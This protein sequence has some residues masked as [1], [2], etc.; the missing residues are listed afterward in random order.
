MEVLVVYQFCTFGGVERMLL[1]RAIAFKNAEIDVKLSIGY[2]HDSGA[3]QDFQGFVAAQDLSS[4]VDP[5]I[6]ESPADSRLRREYGLILVIDTPDAL[7]YLS[8]RRNLYVECHT[9]YRQN[10]KYLDR[11]PKSVR[12]V[13]VP[14]DSF[15]HLIQGEFPRLPPL[16]T[17][18]NPI[19]GDFFDCPAPGA[20]IF[21]KRP[22]AYLGR[23][24][25]LK[26]A[27]EAFQVFRQLA[28]VAEVMFFIVGQGA[29]EPDTLKTLS[30][31]G[32]LGKAF[33]RNNLPFES[34]PSLVGMVKASRGAYF[35]PSKGESFGLSVAEFMAGGVPV[36]VSDIPAHRE[37]VD[38]DE[39]FLYKLGDIDAAARGVSSLL[40]HWDAMSKLASRYAEKFRQDRFV[41][42][43][44]SL[45]DAAS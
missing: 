17:L 35:S 8:G 28:Q 1:N 30:A 32:I 31:A 37:L 9:P 19:P 36:V 45:F 4:G 15:G 23:L 21:A 3:L 41:Q 11:I 5:F 13:I 12:G 39:R 22:I 40:E 2:L 33:I 7:P 20:R 16:H 24:D 29:A 38:G 44:Q 34:V 14:S 42:Q 18:S 6:I 27:R 10:R 26:N 25:E 43:W